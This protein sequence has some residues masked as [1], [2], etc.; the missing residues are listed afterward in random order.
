MEEISGKVEIVKDLFN[1][2]NYRRDEAGKQMDRIDTFEL[3]AVIILCIG[4]D[5]DHFISNIIFIFGFENG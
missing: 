5:F 1:H 3:I 4:G 2:L